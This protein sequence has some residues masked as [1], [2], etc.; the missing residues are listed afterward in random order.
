[1]ICKNCGVELEDDML[2]CP[3]CGEPVDNNKGAAKAFITEYGRQIFHYKKM[4]EPQKKF[5]WEIVSLILFSSTTATF[6]V[7]FILNHRLTWSEL[8]VAVCL[9]VFCYVSLFAFWN[10]TTIVEMAG[11]FILSSVCLVILDAF[12]TRISWSV[13]LGIPLLLTGNLVA[14]ALIAV[15]RKSRYK[16][17]NL[18]AYAFLGAAVLCLCIDGLLSFFKTGLFQLQWSVIT[19]ACIIPVVI[20]LLFVHFRLKRGRS[21]KRTFHV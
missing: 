20:V 2:V 6:V 21:L 16:G 14:A 13:R 17:I 11:G 8:P 10:Q 15:I 3:L 9:T 18:L 7:D 4:S 1:M 5:T 19:T 12:T